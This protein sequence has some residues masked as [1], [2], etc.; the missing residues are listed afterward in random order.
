VAVSSIS[1]TF[2]RLVLGVLPLETAFG[3]TASRFARKNGAS[4]HPA[5]GDFRLS[6][7][8]PTETSSHK[9]RIFMLCF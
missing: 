5:I 9:Q 2:P 1:P 8:H 3:A 4:L 6:G 7:E